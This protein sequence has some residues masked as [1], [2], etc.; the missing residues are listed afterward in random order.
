V[1]RFWWTCSVVL[2]LLGA[3]ESPAFACSCAAIRTF[4][5]QVQAAPV[6]VVGRVTLVR[7]VP[8]QEDPASDLIIVRPPF[9]GTG[10]TLAVASVAKGEVSRRQIRIWDFG[11]GSCGNALYGLTIGTSVVVGLWPVADTPAIE[12]ADWGTASLIPE[13]DYVSSGACGPS[14]QLLTADEVAAWT[15]RKIPV[16]HAGASLDGRLPSRRISYMR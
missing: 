9:M 11:Y 14:V 13:S 15:G 12:R 3:T 10:V 5:Q 1:T 2:V 8:P 16:A 7:E 6:V 4:Q